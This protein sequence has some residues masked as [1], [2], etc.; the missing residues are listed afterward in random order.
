M[1]SAAAWA[2]GAA[3]DWPFV[4]R[5]D[6]L[7]ALRRVL[8][9]GGALK[10]AVICGPAGAG[11]SRLA[12]QAAAH[13]ASVGAAPLYLRGSEAARSIPAGMGR[14]PLTSPAPQRGNAPRLIVLD[15]A[16]LLDDVSAL[17]LDQWL[18]ADRIRLIAT[19]RLGARLPG[20]L[21]ALLTSGALSRIDLLPLAE[22]DTAGL[23]ADALGGAVSPG[24]VREIHRL[25]AGNP[26][27]IRELLLD[28]ASAG[29]LLRTDG[30]W[31]LERVA[32]RSAG[33]ADLLQSRL[34]GLTGPQRAALEV[35]A[36]AEGVGLRLLLGL[37]DQPDIEALE[38]SGLI[39]VDR[40]DRRLPTR[41]CHPLYRELI[42]R[43]TPVS[44]RLGYARRLADALESTGLRRAEDL[45]RWAVWRLDGGGVPDRRKM[46][47]AARHAAAARA[48]AGLRER[49]AAAAFEY[50]REVG[51]GLLLYRARLDAGRFE[52]AHALLESLGDL[53]ACDRDRV[54]LAAA[55]AYRLSW[56]T[57]RLDQ[58]LAVIEDA[59]RTVR[60]PQAAAH[61][62]AH[63]GLLLAV[64][65]D[66]AAAVNELEPLM[67]TPW[68][69]V[70][71]LAAGGAALAYPLIGRFSA[72][73]R[74]FDLALAERERDDD[75]GSPDPA[76]PA[77]AVL[78]A[79][80]NGD[81]QGAV[82]QAR[83]AIEDALD[84]GDAPG[85]AWARAGIASV[86][87]GTG[88]LP[89]AAAQAAEAARLFEALGE[90]HGRVW[91][92]A[93]GMS[94]AAQ[95]GDR[96]HARRLAESLELSPLPPQLRAMNTDVIRA[97]AW[98]DA[99]CG[100]SDGARQRLATAAD[101]WISEGMVAPAVLGALDLFRLGH[102]DAA[103]RLIDRIA[104]PDDWPLGCCAHRLIGA[105]DKPNALREAAEVL[106]TQGFSLYAAETFAAAALAAG[107]PVGA[108][109]GA[110]PT[111]G[112]GRTSRTASRALALAAAC[113]ART[114]LLNRLGPMRVL[115]PREQQIA[116]HAADGLSNRQIAD[117]L[118][119]SERTVENH[120]GRIYGK[121]GV[122]GRGELR[123]ALRP[124]PA[125]GPAAPR[126]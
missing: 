119:L 13:H 113:D 99:V 55:H 26:L 123:G 24:S 51:D 1:E 53:A 91:C 114:P 12:R 89:A 47:A 81:P 71:A 11:K 63:R 6:E 10:G 23:L 36:L 117:R 80:H 82:A 120:L 67:G 100:N 30:V 112:S 124:D 27:F 85:Q 17:A 16:D 54:A 125:S 115:T 109:I 87:L 43:S 102:P 38:R 9:T 28:A 77:F 95:R 84:R 61:L 32:A 86:Y 88:N 101:A 21:G 15:D 108:V 14:G 35:V 106:A 83:A 122:A 60:E 111:T 52:P 44:A 107:E 46:A 58:G 40:D 22:H 64:A 65:G 45:V 79:C 3:G 72:G 94:A 98:H 69:Q 59:A 70:R 116:E 39:D 121:L 78:A 76:L 105:A 110:D 74:A 49:L 93:T 92:L 57:G 126:S 2:G 103:A 68:P 34:S 37:V 62:A 25:S 8:T 96:A 5:G 66:F 50:S 41:V 18:S 75:A 104:V 90:Q 48:E 118:R 19:L 4:G 29:T 42:A 56:T 73:L 7:A 97:W 33:L 31:R 20:V